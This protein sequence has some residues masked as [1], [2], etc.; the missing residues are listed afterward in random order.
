MAPL[1]RG[2]AEEARPEAAHGHDG[3]RSDEQGAAVRPVP[4]DSKCEE[5]RTPA[6]L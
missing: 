6:A 2:R 1:C 5:V 4:A 3:E